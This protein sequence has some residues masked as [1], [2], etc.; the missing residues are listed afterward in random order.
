MYPYIPQGLS[1]FLFE[2]KLLWWRF[3][4]WSEWHRG[5]GLGGDIGGAAR[6]WRCRWWHRNTL[7]RRWIGKGQ[8]KRRKRCFFRWS[9]VKEFEGVQWE[10]V[11]DLGVVRRTGQSASEIVSVAARGCTRRRGSAQVGGLGKSPYLRSLAYFRLLQ[12]R[13]RKH[14][15]RGRETADCR[16]SLPTFW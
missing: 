1:K 7:D 13:H 3:N 4:S 16:W 11:G 9:Y 6:R 15:P 14:R 12:L 5:D 2:D 8:Y 10:F